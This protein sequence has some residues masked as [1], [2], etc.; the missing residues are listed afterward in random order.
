MGLVHAV[1]WIMPIALH[2]MGEI[3]FEAASLLNVKSRA[4]TCATN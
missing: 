2:T 1:F 4:L 3:F